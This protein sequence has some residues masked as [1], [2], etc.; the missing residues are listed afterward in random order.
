MEFFNKKEE[1][2]DIQITPLGKRLMQLG[3]FKPKYYA[4]YDNDIVYDGKFADLNEEQNQIQERI[5]ETPRIKQQIYL[6]SAEKKITSNTTDKDLMS[7]DENLF[8][9]KSLTGV[10]TLATEYNVQ[11]EESKQKEFEMFGPLGKMALHSSNAPSW[12]IDFFETELTGATT[13]V[14]G[15]NNQRIPRLECDLQYKFRINKVDPKRLLEPQNEDFLFELEENLFISNTQVTSDGTYISVVPDALFIKA[16]ENNTD[17][18][19]ENF[20]IEKYWPEL[21]K[22]Q[23]DLICKYNK[24]F[25]IDK[26]WPELTEYQRELICEYNENFDADKYWPELTES[27]RNLICRLYKDIDID[28]DKYWPE[29]TEYQRDL[30]CKYAFKNM[31]IEKHWPKLT[32]RQKKSLYRRVVLKSKERPKITA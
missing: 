5:K 17:F 12:K 23:R 10:Q 13:I 3:Q 25:N 4:F 21:T 27:Q 1:V 18:L 8:Q 11:N 22:H 14:T 2:L 30:V 16:T 19:N 24:N 26:Y 31:D 9:N 6:Y 32:K 7:Y 20:D 28:I 15:S 29:L